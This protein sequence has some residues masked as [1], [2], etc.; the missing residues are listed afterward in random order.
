L[1]SLDVRIDDG[2]LVAAV[3]DT[4]VGIAGEDLPKLFSEFYQA[5]TAT[6]DPGAATLR[7]G[8]GL[9]LALTKGFVELHGG[10]I[11]VE[12]V[13]GKGSTFTMRFPA[14]AKATA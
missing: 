4:G 5:T 8:T 11:S 6:S 12:S 14:G 13:V 3:S 7:E 1:I 9:G 10:I 2:A